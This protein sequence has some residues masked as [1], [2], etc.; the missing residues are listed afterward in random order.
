VINDLG[1]SI[2]KNRDIELRMTAVDPLMVELDPKLFQRVLENLL[3]NALKYS[4]E[5]T[6]IHLELD[7][8]D[9]QVVIQ[10]RDHGIGIPKEDMP[11]L[12]E[13]FHRANNVGDRQGTG[14]GLAIVKRAVDAHHGTVVVETELDAGTNFRITLPKKQPISE[15][16]IVRGILDW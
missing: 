8:A 2:A 7:D 1:F 13:A 15:T 10:I 6:P 11:G 12:F 16:Q 3:T 14:L 4:P 5:D 9:E